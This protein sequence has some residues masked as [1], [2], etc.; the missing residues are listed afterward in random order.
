MF[1]A[2][3]GENFDGNQY[4]LKALKVGAKFAVVDDS[5]LGN[6][7]NCI[8][9]E[10]CLQTLQQLANY[11]RQQFKG[12]VLAI[13]GSNGKTTTKELAYKVLKTQFKI[14]Y[15]KGNLN[16][17][18]GV[19]LTLLSLN[20]NT[21]I[22]IVEMGANHL[23][24]IAN[25]C[26]ITDPTHGIITNIGSAHIGEFGGKENIIRAKSELFDYLLK[27][28]RQ[29]FINSE[30]DVLNNMSKRFSEPI[31]YPN[32]LCQ[33]KNS[34]PY[35]IYND[36][37]GNQHDTHLIGIYNFFNISAAVT[38][39]NYFGIKNNNI[40]H[41]VK[42]FIPDNNR[43]QILK[44]G[45]NTIIMDAYNANPDST[46]AALT[47]LSKFKSDNKIAILGDMKELGDY[48]FEEHKKAINFSKKINL[49]TIYFVGEEYSKIDSNNFST[50]DSLISYLKK[51]P[52]SNTVVL[53]KGSRSMAMEQLIKINE[54]WN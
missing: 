42:E 9:V 36:E 7:V 46:K 24:E 10:D 38:I 34:T 41:A 43:S 16:N 51:H 30:D 12:K 19:P 11:H 20:L 52:I 3:K 29:V 37:K 13:T 14:Q 8:L 21:E 4:V 32:K 2:I 48:S 49:E 54:I 17:Y 25:L 22:A 1:F 45:S 23:G 44:I 40:H 47:N 39:G 31:F 50:I 53:L 35:V 27:N 33:L 18:I 28:N 15:T 5:K 6:E 26:K